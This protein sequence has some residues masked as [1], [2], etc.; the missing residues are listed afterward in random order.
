MTYSLGKPCETGTHLSLGFILC[1]QSPFLQAVVPNISG[2]TETTGMAACNSTSS[3]KVKSGTEAAISAFYLQGYILL[4]PYLSWILRFPRMIS[5]KLLISVKS[6]CLGREQCWLIWP[7]CFPKSVEGWILYVNLMNIF[8]ER[9]LRSV[10]LP[11]IMNFLMSVLF[12]WPP[13]LA[14]G[15]IDQFLKNQC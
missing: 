3:A 13:T 14:N 15:L 6:P 10:P 12:P 7:E 1:F 5:S 9:N 11:V 2:P 8:D 4:Q